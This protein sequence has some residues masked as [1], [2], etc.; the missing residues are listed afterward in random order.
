MSKEKCIEVIEDY[1]MT[2]LDHLFEEGRHDDATSVFLEFV[3]DGK[4]PEKWTFLEH[5]EPI[6]LDLEDDL[7]S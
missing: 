1:Y 5:L 3:V 6:R 2:T 4:E 7:Y